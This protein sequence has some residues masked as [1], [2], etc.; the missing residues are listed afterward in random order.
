[1]QAPV[2]AP[3][4]A[5]GTLGS[6]ESSF[7]IA[8]WRDAGSDPSPGR[9]Y[10]APLH[11]HHQD[12]EAWYVLEGTLCVLS[13]EE[14]ICAPAGSAVFVPRGK[15]HT[16]WNPGPGPVRYLLLMTPRIFALIQAIHALPD[17]SRGSLDAVFAR[18]DSALLDFPP[19][20]G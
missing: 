11:V 19:G 5:G 17:R 7:V 9:R 2:T 18:H 16:F 12:D 15:G 20:R 6:A 4:L 3:P 1:M 13:G 8:E 10:L 14:E